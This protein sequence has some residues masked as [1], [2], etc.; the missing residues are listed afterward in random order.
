MLHFGQLHKIVSGKQLHFQD[1]TPITHLFFDSRKAFPTDGA[2]FIAIR[3]KNHDGHQYITE[4]HQRGFRQFVIESEKA[5]DAEVKKSSNVVVVNDAVTAMQK[6]A[7]NHR[8]Q[9]K[10]PVL[11]ITGSNGKT[12]IKEWLFHML[13]DDYKVIRNPKS[14]NSQIGVPL[15]VW[16]MNPGH[17]LGI[18]EAGISLPGEMKNL[19]KIIKP[20]IG[21]FSN[22]G[23]AHDE[24][25][26][27]LKQKV[28]E[29]A[30]LFKNSKVVIYN[31]NFDLVDK[32]LSDLKGPKLISWGY[33]KNGTFNVKRKKEDTSTRLQIISKKKRYKFVIPFVDD[34]STENLINCI[35]F[36]IYLKVDPKKIQSRL[37]TLV[38]VRMRLE[39]K[40][41]INNCHLVDDSYNND[42]GGLE[43]ALD[44]INQQ[45]LHKKK[46]IIL[47]DIL[48]TG[49]PSAD[50]INTINQ[51]L[52]NKNIDRL[53]GIGPDIY[54]HYQAFDIPGKF[55]KSTKS[56]LEAFSDMD[57]QNEMVL[58][59][60]A[61]VFSFEKIAKKLQQKI[62]QTVLEFNL[63]ALTHNLNYYRSKLKANT[64]VMVMVK[65]FAYGS[66]SYIVAKH[67]QFHRVDYLAVA[68][69]DEGVA[70]RK[71]EISLPIM[72]M[73]PSN[74]SFDK[75]FQYGLEPEIYNLKILKSLLNYCKENKTKARIHL[76]LDTGMHRLGFDPKEVS[77]LCE[78][79]DSE[80]IDIKS[81]FSHLAGQD[82][83]QHT[84][85]SIEQV[86]IFKE[87]ADIIEKKVGYQPVRH[88]VNSAGIIRFPEY[89]F[90]MV[91]LG[92]GLYGV[93][94]NQLEQGQLEQVSSLKTIISQIT[95]VTKG[96]TIG[97]GR[98]G[99]ADDDITIATIPIGYA[100]G[101]SRSFS[102]GVGEV[103]IDGHKAPVIGNVCMDMTMVDITGIP[104]SEGD[105][106][107]I[108]GKGLNVVEVAKKINTI[109]YEILTNVSHRVKRVF[110]SD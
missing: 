2:L 7:A 25:F 19:E 102:N 24:G 50:L 71:R 94:S 89:H 106:V 64:K 60:G 10:Y 65:A 84:E 108:F 36:L 103:L 110:I 14:F 45:N 98:S 79:L 101:F 73:N 59:K 33:G 28:K 90:D 104:A 77:I 16:M 81:I 56:F 20:Q 52:H 92:I 86:N 88:I 26:K 15:S 30:I 66:D 17:N 72:V 48:Q 63:S 82:E 87:T 42:L 68:Y 107:I 95:A 6:I 9:F 85:F 47:S 18:F 54:K 61:R 78:L 91:R 53:I 21:I 39:L 35:I 57:F 109:P 37:S 44:F 96:E 80:W 31:K 38:P 12:I 46:T 29:K 41:G 69:V 3:G 99:K 27:S 49:L 11:G 105:E 13:S 23:S 100:D 83:E 67:L 40:S 55:Y 62:H 34:A 4:L 76:K 58:I 22:I 1:N 70:L 75:I 43:I 32:I 74:E 97:Y 8:K 93:E 51:L 5:L